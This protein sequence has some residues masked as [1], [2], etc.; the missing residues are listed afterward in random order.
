MREKPKKHRYDF[1]RI[2]LRISQKQRS[3][4]LTN[5]KPQTSAFH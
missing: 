4:N 2:T 3:K 5:F 1:S